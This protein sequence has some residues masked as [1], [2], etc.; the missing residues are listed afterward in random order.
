MDLLWS[1]TP[2]SLLASTVS[3]SYPT[4]PYL[5][6]LPSLNPTPT[7]LRLLSPSLSTSPCEHPYSPPHFSVHLHSNP[8]SHPPITSYHFTHPPYPTF[9]QFKSHISSYY[10][11]LCQL[12][13]IDLK[14]ELR[15]ALRWLLGRIGTEYSILHYSESAA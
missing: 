12:V 10:P 1:D 9:L 2:C 7:S 14:M 4:A 8:C 5:L 6:S 11:E 15:T 13:M 3:S